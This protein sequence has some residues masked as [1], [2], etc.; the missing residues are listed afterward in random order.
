[1]KK[2]VYAI[3]IMCLA[4]VAISSCKKEEPKI[5]KRL[6]MCGDEWDK[7]Y[8][9]YN[10]E[11][12]ITDVK[13][14]PSNEA[15]WGGYERIWTFT[16]NGKTATVK[17]VKEGEEQNP[18]TFVFGN[19][20]YVQTFTDTWGDV[21]KATYDLEGHLLKVFKVED[22]KDV[23]KCNCI[24]ENGNLKKWS[25]FSDG[26][27]QF[28]NQSFFNE[29]NLGGIYPDATDKAGIDRWMIELGFFGKPSK[30]L[31]DQAAW[32]GA[33]DIATQTY[34]KDTDGFVIKVEKFYGGELDQTYEYVWEKITK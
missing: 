25:R 13:R 34:T 32:D 28:K 10:A 23:L 30:Q 18:L 29:E 2:I 9:T 7:Y 26:Q 22:G 4:T 15:G 27:E 12:N 16:W 8:F 20:G 3:A 33:E 11:G 6:T 19:N 31:L 24:W 14:N 21:R 1:M 5:Q 17:Y